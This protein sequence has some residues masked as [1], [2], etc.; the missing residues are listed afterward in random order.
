MNN[1][2]PYLALGLK[3]YPPPRVRQIIKAYYAI[4]KEVHPD[5]GKDTAEEVIKF[6]N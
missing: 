4:I 5:K 3:P 2:C 1:F 6:R